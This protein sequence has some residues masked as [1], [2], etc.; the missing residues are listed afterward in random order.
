MKQVLLSAL[1]ILAVTAVSAA[2][3]PSRVVLKIGSTSTS[4]WAVVG[5]VVRDHIGNFLPGKPTIET[6]IVD[7]A[8]GMQLARQMVSTEPTDGSVFS[9]MSTSILQNYVLDP[10][11]FDFS[12]EGVHWIGSLAKTVSYCVTK[13][14][15]PTTLTDEGLVFGSSNKQSNFYTNAALIRHLVNPSASIVVGFKNETELVAALDRGEIGA[16]CGP[17]RSTYEREGR[18]STQAIA[19]AL[20]RPDAIAALG[21][22]DVFANVTGFDRQAVDLALTSTVLFY[23]MVL[24]PDASPETVE[25]YRNAFTAM[26]ADPAFQTDIKAKIAEYAPMSGPEVEAFMKTL[27]TT[28]PAVVA[29]ALELLK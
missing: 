29:H 26:N 4:S 15:T 14:G 9:M 2:E 20:G 11:V 24:P 17:T 18:A 22:P 25:I 13:K 16:Y 23:G 19:G 8:R 1:A 10:S 5:E 12:P 21:V 28:D 3:F 27:L 6:E 7:G